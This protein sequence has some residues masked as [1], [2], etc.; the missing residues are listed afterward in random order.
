MYVTHSHTSIYIYV[1]TY[2]FLYTAFAINLD[3]ILRNPKLKLNPDGTPGFLESN[4]LSL[5]TSK[6]ELEPKASNCTKVKIHV[7]A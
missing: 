5:I 1:T 4:F 7:H 3:I 6:E 2:S